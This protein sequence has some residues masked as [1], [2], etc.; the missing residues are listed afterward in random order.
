VPG[1]HRKFRYYLTKSD[2]AAIPSSREHLHN[3]TVLSEDPCLLRACRMSGGHAYG[4]CAKRESRAD[5]Q[6]ARSIQKK[7]LSQRD[8]GRLGLSEDPAL[9]VALSR[10]LFALLYCLLRSKS[11]DEINPF[12]VPNCCV[13]PGSLPI[14]CIQGYLPNA[15]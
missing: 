1:P 7:G 6:G 3:R 13:L 14:D 4:R 9:F 15:S 10:N 2:R 5:L 8:R 12:P 11:M